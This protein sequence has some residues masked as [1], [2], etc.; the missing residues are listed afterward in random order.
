MKKNREFR[1][2]GLVKLKTDIGQILMSLLERR[3]EDKLSQWSSD[4]TDWDNSRKTRIFYTKLYFNTERG[5][6]EHSK[7]SM[8]KPALPP[9]Q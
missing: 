5:L 8:R 1:L 6:R 9:P 4:W 2:T 7:Y 3:E